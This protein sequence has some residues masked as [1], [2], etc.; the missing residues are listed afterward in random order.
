[1]PRTASTP[2]AARVSTVARAPRDGPARTDAPTTRRLRS[3][4]DMPNA[5]AVDAGG[6]IVSRN[7]GAG[8]RTEVAAGAHTVVADEP[9]SFGGTDRGPTP[10]DLLLAA[11]GSCTAMTVRMY[12]RRKQWPLERVEVAMRTARSHGADCTECAERSP[13]APLRLERRVTLEG[14]LDDAQRERLLWIADRCP[15]KQ[16]LGRGAEVVP[17]A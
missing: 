1:M 7:D 6:W 11:I 10:Y 8:F 3:P 2:T 14:P 9:T 5:P 17:S 13:L 15:V 4:M 12:A 16:A